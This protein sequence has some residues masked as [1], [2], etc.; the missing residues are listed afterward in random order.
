MHPHELLP[1]A[2]LQL[3]QERVVL[4]RPFKRLRSLDRGEAVVDDRV[5]VGTVVRCGFESFERWA[6]G[7][8]SRSQD[9]IEHPLDD[10]GSKDPR[11]PK[12]KAVHSA[13]HGRRQMLAGLS[14]VP[15]FDLRV[16]AQSQTLDFRNDFI[17]GMKVEWSFG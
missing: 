9:P 3:V 11:Q 13:G 4:N 8:F 10:R 5:V 12:P 16:A 15:V 2:D 14:E 7:H 6:A 1:V 17:A